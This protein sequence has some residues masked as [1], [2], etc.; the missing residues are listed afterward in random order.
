MFALALGAG[1]LLV[2]ENQS[3]EAMLTLGAYVFKYRHVKFSEFC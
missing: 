3:F 2:S 1:C